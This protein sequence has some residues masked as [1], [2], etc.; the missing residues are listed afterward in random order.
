MARSL[1]T[2]NLREKKFKTYAFGGV[3]LDTMGTPEV[4]NLIIVYGPEKNGKTWFAL[5]FAEYMS[6]FEKVLYVSAEEGL[7]KTFVDTI[8]RIGIDTKNKSLHYLAY[9]PLDELD[10]KLSKRKA[11]KIVFI[12]NVTVF[13]DELKNGVLR[14]FLRKHTN[15]LFVF[16]AH[17]EDTT[18]EPYTATAKMIKKL[19]DIIIRIEGLTCFISGR[20]PGGVLSIDKEKSALY[21]GTILKDK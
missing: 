2:R 13:K 9:T 16:L 15:K 21:H 12:D 18:Q 14:K 17:Q 1:T 5:K 7:K 10:E 20:C 6:S 11:P 3:W 8:K 4:N 19:A